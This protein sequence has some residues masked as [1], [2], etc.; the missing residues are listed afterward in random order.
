MTA[1][2]QQGLIFK[3]C[4][5]HRPRPL[6]VIGE[7]ILA[8]ERRTPAS[9]M[10][11]EIFCG[12]NH[13]RGP[14]PSSPLSLKGLAKSP[15]SWASWRPELPRSAHGCPCHWVS[16]G[17]GTMVSE[18]CLV[19]AASVS[20]SGENE[21]RRQQ[22][23]E[24]SA[25]T[26]TRLL[27]SAVVVDLW[28]P[29]EASACPD[30]LSLPHHQ[31]RPGRLSKSRLGPIHGPLSRCKGFA[32]TFLSCP[33]PSPAVSE[34][35]LTGPFPILSVSQVWPLL[36]TPIAPARS[37]P[38]LSQARTLA[39]Q[40]LS[41]RGSGQ[42]AQPRSRATRASLGLPNPALRSPDL[43]VEA[44]LLPV[45]FKAP[46]QTRFHPHSL[47]LHSSQFLSAVRGLSRAAN[48]L[49]TS[50]CRINSHSCVL[51]HM[52]CHL[53]GRPAPAGLER[54]PG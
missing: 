18:P 12:C 15:L 7:Q 3:R 33:S 30:L 39:P 21:N 49:S 45:A 11:K 31:P 19:A 20:K 16:L 44:Q 35:F 1:G 26:E 54:C 22:A 48:A 38:P 36:L 53:P 40:P 23:P 42:S 37:R 50:L 9:S 10:L 34:L 2:R 52:K 28:S 25:G 14:R 4:Y 27:P 51:G 17:M 47:P 6:L 41:L 5:T 32:P 24:P 46:S 29:G 13:Q 8:F 43:R